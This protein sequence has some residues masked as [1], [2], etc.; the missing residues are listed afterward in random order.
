[1]RIVHIE[2]QM[3]WAGQ[4]RQGFQLAKGLHERGHR[5]LVVCQPGS[6]VAERA[7]R[8]G[9]PVLLLRM[10]GAQLFPSAAR[11]ASRLRRG[12]YDLIHAHGARDHVLAALAAMACPG[13]VLVRTKHNLTRLRGGWLH[14]LVTDRFV[15]VSR[16]A[17][18]VLAASGIPARK[19][20]IVYDGVD[21]D[22]FSPRRAD[23]ALRNALGIR[24]D[25]FVVGVTGRLGSKSKGIP[26]L[27]RAMK[28]VVA[29]APET[30]LLLVGRFEPALREVAASLGLGDRVLFAGFRTDVA[31]L[32]ACMDLY[33]QPSLREAL[34]SSVL[35]A[36]AMGKP[37]VASA[38][39]GV[40]EAVVPGETGILCRPGDANDL[41]GAILTLA[42]RRETLREMGLRARERAAAIFSLDRMVRETE[43]LYRELVG[44]R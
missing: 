7:E 2:K 42:E 15:A 5:V 19:V 31:D 16:A 43:D 34:S 25:E 35:E 37:V 32:L 28:A 4:T 21:L 29:R 10:A 33:V 39:G 20:R 24:E 6:A 23:P 14:G 13:I 26:V 30:R 22:A 44:E 11:L 17:A 1:M 40:P 36:M 3:K 38:V 9:I 12:E 27:L 8:A 41:A 18:E